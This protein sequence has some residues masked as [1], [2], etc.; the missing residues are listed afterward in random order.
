MILVTVIVTA[1]ILGGYFASHYLMAIA[2]IFWIQY[3]A[4][5]SYNQFR[6]KSMPKAKGITKYLLN[7]QLRFFLFEFIAVLGLGMLLK[8][9][10]VH[11][12]AAALGAWWLFSWNFYRYYKN[13]SRRV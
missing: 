5:L 7:P 2:L 6:K 1:G 11:I 13:K 8:Y 3:T 12:G 4:I 10:T 9:D